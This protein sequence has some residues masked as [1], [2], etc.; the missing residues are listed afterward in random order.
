MFSHPS[1]PSHPSDPLWFI[2]YQN[3]DE[4][5]RENIVTPQNK[6]KTG[7]ERVKDRKYE[8]MLIITVEFCR[9]GNING[10]EQSM[11]EGRDE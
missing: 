8:N 3:K 4:I 1:H 5:L 11:L 6:K 2:K 10:I 7:Y 9:Q